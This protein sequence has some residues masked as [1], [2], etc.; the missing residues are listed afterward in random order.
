MKLPKSKM[1]KKKKKYQ[2]EK[3]KSSTYT[4]ALKK[5]IKGFLP[6]TETPYFILYQ[7]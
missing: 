7:I 6:P 5:E 4:V 3:K 2:T 1:K